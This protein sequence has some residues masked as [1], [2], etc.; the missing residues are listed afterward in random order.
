MDT[1]AIQVVPSKSYAFDTDKLIDAFST[2]TT[3]SSL[4]AQQNI[5]HGME[6]EPYFQ[7]MIDTHDAP[8]LWRTIWNEM[9]RSPEFG[10]HLA[11]ASIA[12]CTGMYGWEDC[13][14]LYHY[15]AAGPADVAVH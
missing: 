4:V 1:I 7:I 12:V 2:L 3:K 13:S 6:D 15:D 11:Y 8:A 5:N 10:I 9:Y 14:Q